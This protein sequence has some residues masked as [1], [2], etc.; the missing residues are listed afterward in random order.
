MKFLKRLRGKVLGSLKRRIVL[1]RIPYYERRYSR[2]VR[3][4]ARTM[5]KQPGYRIRVL[6]LVNNNTKWN[7]HS[8]FTAM[9]ESTQ[10]DPYIFVCREPQNQLEAKTRNGYAD[11]IAFFEERKIPFIHGYDAASGKDISPLRFNPDIVFYIQPWGT[12]KGIT[13]IH[14]ISRKALTCYIPYAMQVADYEPHKNTP[15][16]NYVWRFMVPSRLNAELL[17][18]TMDNRGRNCRVA[19][20]PKLD[21]YNRLRTNNAR[22]FFPAGSETK[23]RIIY[24]PHHSFDRATFATFDWNGRE[25]L[26]FAEE[27]PDTAWVFKP[28]PRLKYELVNHGIMTM[29]DADA[30]YDAWRCL[31]N[32]TVYEQGNYF[33][34]F[35]ESTLLI[36]DCISFLGEYLP[37]GHPVIL[38][39]NPRSV[40]YN[41]LGTIITDSYYKAH[42]LKE[43]ID[44]IGS[45]AIG[46]QDPRKTERQRAAEHFLFPQT[47]AEKILHIVT[48]EIS[49]S[50]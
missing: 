22:E 12:L 48:S 41:E 27:H 31:P 34:L 7:A 6:F 16:M 49:L 39:V 35:I 28:H 1:F 50:Y 14:T 46:G 8:V 17:K 5:L 19:G 30:Y 20:Y 38:P 4:F 26:K 21:E 2:R 10:F 33:G 42:T 40:G 9:Q 47:A 36:T 37:S 13:D 29:E 11:D 18:K 44:L 15:F 24:A 23:P 25:L 3:R 45:V 43:L 32:A